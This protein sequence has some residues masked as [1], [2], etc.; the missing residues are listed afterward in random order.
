MHESRARQHHPHAPPSVKGPGDECPHRAWGSGAGHTGAAAHSPRAP[1]GRR[2][3]PRLQ[4]RPAAGRGPHRRGLPQRTRRVARRTPAPAAPGR[5]RPGTAAARRHPGQGREHLL[6]DRALPRHPGLPGL[7]LPAA[8]CPLRVG[9]PGAGRGHRRRAGAAP[10][11]SAR[12]AAD[13]DGD[14]TDRHRARVRAFRVR[15]AADGPSVEPVRGDALAALRLGPDGRDRPRRR[16]PVTVAVAVAAASAADPAGDRG[17]GEPLLA[18]RDRGGRAARPRARAD[19][20]PRRTATTTGRGT[21][22]LVPAEEPVLVGAG[23]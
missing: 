12:P 8:P 1:A 13:A 4:A 20:R 16:H 22:T 18:R 23:R 11:P 21:R 9:P 17:H 3:L 14:G 6:R 5:L 2:A 15:P 7:A 19:P 10:R